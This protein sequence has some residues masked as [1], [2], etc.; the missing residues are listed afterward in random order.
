MAHLVGC[1]IDIRVHPC[2]LKELASLDAPLKILL[3]CEVVVLSVLR[4]AC[5]THRDLVS[6]DLHAY[7]DCRSD[8]NV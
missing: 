5:D 8:R 6:W 1:A 2:I 7:I 3:A 4:G